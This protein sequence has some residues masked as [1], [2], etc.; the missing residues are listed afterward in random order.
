MAVFVAAQASVLIDP[1]LGKGPTGFHVQ[2]AA[3][4]KKARHSVDVQVKAKTAGF[5]AEVEAVKAA[6]E[7]TEINL[8][9][10]DIGITKQITEIRHKYEDLRTQFK[11][12]LL[13]NLKIVGMSQLTQLGPMLASLNTSIVQLSQSSLLLPGILSGVASS[14]RLRWW[15]L[16]G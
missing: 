15:V 16:V 5:L 1:T 8:K 13:L 9:V 3:Q 12:G 11:K 6:S 14:F 4:L 10:N 7:A 2:L